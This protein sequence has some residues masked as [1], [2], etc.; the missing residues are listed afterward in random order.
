M[1]LA[2]SASCIGFS[3]T[4]S[5]D[6]FLTIAKFRGMRLLWTHALEAAGEKPSAD[7][8]LLGR[9]P[10]RIV[11]A[12]DPHV[13][14]LRGTAAAFGAA[15]GGAVG[16]EIL[17]FDSA[18]RG[19]TSFSRRLA[20]NTSLILQKESYLLAVADA[21]A[22]SS[23]AETLTDELAAKAWALFREV[24]A[25]GGLAA[26]IESGFIQGA[27]QL[28]AQERARAVAHRQDKITGVSVF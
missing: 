1:T 14:L 9:M 10:Q 20:R 4:A 24:E 23:Y 22:G 6:I 26:A 28:K 21:A 13:N 11:S 12:Y 3:L 17:P 7:L 18:A 27:L 15:V 19:A 5:A 2:E 8:L 25:K 16:I